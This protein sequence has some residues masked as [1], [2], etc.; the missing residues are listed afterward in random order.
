MAKRGFGKMRFSIIVPVYNVAPYLRDCLDS[1]LNQSLKEWE[2][3][4]VNDGSSDA[5]DSILDE[6][7]AKDDRFKI[8]HKEN[9]G[10]SVARNLAL[11]LATGD[12]VCFL[13]S[14]DIWDSKTLFNINDIINKENPDVLRLRFKEFSKDHTSLK[15]EYTENY[16]IIVGK[17]KINKFVNDELIQN[18]FASLL[19]I[20]RASLGGIRFPVGVKYAED[21]LYSL[22][23]FSRVTTFVQSEF[24]GYYYR[25]R[26]DSAKRCFFESTERLLFLYE[27]ERVAKL[28][29]K[30]PNKSW[31]GWF[32]VLNWILRPKDE[33]RSKELYLLYKKICDQGLI[34]I[35]LLPWYAR[36]SALLYKKWGMKWATRWIYGIIRLI[37]K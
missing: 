12:W 20:R 33:L 1:V 30:I 37:R 13:D 7:A 23:V 11:S 2:C 36:V 10:V 16:K 14:D 25:F 26:N 3:I 22:E 32:S 35:S 28:Y 31:M 9:E 4:C 24:I 6:Y 21:A 34:D 29:P 18:G 19:F 17:D 27:F 8:I 15:S 5:S